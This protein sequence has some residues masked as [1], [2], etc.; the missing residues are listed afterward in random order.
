MAELDFDALL[1]KYEGFTSPHVIIEVANKDIIDS[2]PDI[3]VSDLDI[4]LSSGYEASVASFCLYNVFDSQ[5]GAYTTERIEDMFHLGSTVKIALGYAKSLSYVFTGLITKVN[6]T[7]EDAEFP[8]I[9]VTCMDAKSMMMANNYSKQLTATS[10]DEAVKEIFN[11]AI[12]KNLGEK[13]V[14]SEVSVSE[15][16]DNPKASKSPGAG[17]EGDNKKERP[18]IEM[19]SESDYEFVVKAAK[20]LNYDFF[21]SV[22]EV[23]FRPAK[24]DDSVL[25]S[26]SPKNVLRNFDIEYDIT[27]QVGAIEVRGTDASTGKLISAGTKIKNAW[28]YGNFAGA[29]VKD[30]Q[31]I[32]LDASIHD[33]AEA[34]FRLES[35]VE[36][37]T[38]RF[39]TLSC[40]TV[41]IPELLPGRFVELPTLG[42]GASNKF[43]L[44]SVRHV[45]TKQG[46]YYCQI[47][48]KAKEL[49]KDEKI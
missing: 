19:V 25:F 46:E 4:D 12:Y 39:A 5:T 16:P 48:G 29:L 6:F 9:R 2:F 41:G 31:K 1:E 20:K 22:G 36:D 27:G 21:I 10:Y 26:L 18:T 44:V 42:K 15:T 14:I 23:I 47:T 40:D 24:V 37:I 34:N 8:Y 43:Y 11:L 3:V 13:G 38:Y 32:Y 33:E 49:K 28:S 30:N 45:L 7:F 35:L 17:G